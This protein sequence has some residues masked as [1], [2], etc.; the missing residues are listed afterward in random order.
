MIQ[1]GSI[2]TPPSRSNITIWGIVELVIMFVIGILCLIDFFNLFST[3]IGVRSI[4]SIV[5]DGFGIAGLVFIILALWL[6]S[7]GH[8]KTG[9]L[10]FLV[11]ILIT[12]VVIVWGLIS[13]GSI[14]IRTI[15]TVAFDVFLAYV[16][17]RQ[18]A[19]FTA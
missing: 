15:L 16:L 18:S 6:G 3:E 17:W 5:G 2:D 14:G 12:L 19:Q 7:G 9:I 1:C 8:F 13:G 4:I 10:C 11:S